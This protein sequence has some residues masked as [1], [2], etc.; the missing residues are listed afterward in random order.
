LSEIRIIGKII[1]IATDNHCVYALCED[2][3]IWAFFGG[4][5]SELPTPPRQ[6][7]EKK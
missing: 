1:Q 3:S 5:W 7:E 6:I 4:K 2:G